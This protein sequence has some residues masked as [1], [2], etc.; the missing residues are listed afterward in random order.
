MKKKHNNKEHKN[1]GA[2]VSLLGS[3]AMETESAP[4]N[5]HSSFDTGNFPGQC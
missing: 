3:L 2:I 5:S 1:H 4:A